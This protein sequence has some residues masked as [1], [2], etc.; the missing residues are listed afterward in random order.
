ML[1]L[2]VANTRFQR[3]RRL[4]LQRSTAVPVAAPVASA[5]AAPSVAPSA[6]LAAT[7]SP[8]PSTVL[9]AVSVAV[10]G[11]ELTS[12]RGPRRGPRGASKRGGADFGRVGVVPR[13]DAELGRDPLSDPFRVVE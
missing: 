2:S 4:L 12:G 7:S 8:V 5:V 13:G 1:L 11:L 3:P 10:R 9:D 6:V